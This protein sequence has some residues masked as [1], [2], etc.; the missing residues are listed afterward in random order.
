[1]PT[2]ESLRTP[3]ATIGGVIGAV[4]GG[5]IGHM[6]M[7]PGEECSDVI[8]LCMPGTPWGLLLGMFTGAVAGLFVGA[9]AA[10]GQ[11]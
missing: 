2:L 10:K 5:F 1:M 4:T 8:P 6:V 3:E 9:S 7:P 11:Q